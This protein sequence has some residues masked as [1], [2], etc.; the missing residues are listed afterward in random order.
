[1]W[2]N[3]EG[4]EMIWDRRVGGGGVHCVNGFEE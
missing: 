4:W 2:R 1:M 3:Y